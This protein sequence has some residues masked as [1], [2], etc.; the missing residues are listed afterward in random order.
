[1]VFLKGIINFSRT[2][3]FQTSAVLLILFLLLKQ[4]KFCEGF[5]YDQ[6]FY[7]GAE[8]VTPSVPPAHYVLLPTPYFKMFLERFLN[9]FPPPHFEP[10]SLLPPT[11]T[12]TFA[13]STSLP[14]P[15]IPN[16]TFNPTLS[17]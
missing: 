6:N 12:T 1:M 5:V 16:K 15:P 17:F 8:V 3:V 7:G 14:P 9:K 10:F 2:A 11:T 4:C 13:P